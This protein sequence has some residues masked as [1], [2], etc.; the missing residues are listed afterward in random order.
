[1]QTGKRLFA[2]QTGKEILGDV[3]RF[4]L[5][6]S[7]PANVSVEGIPILDIKAREGVVVELRLGA[8]RSRTI[9]QWV[10]LNAPSAVAGCM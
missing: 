2:D 7:A 8:R 9:V 6:I 10:V 1:M 5:R 3:F 4:S